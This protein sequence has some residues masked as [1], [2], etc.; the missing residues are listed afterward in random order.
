M[1]TSGPMTRIDARFEAL[2]A[3][4]R[5]GLVTFVMAGDPDPETALALL[6]QSRR[7]EQ[8]AE[9]S[10]IRLQLKQNTRE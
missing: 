8:P 10:F 9:R 1:L 7:T 4:R 5:A 6:E 3:A 2:R